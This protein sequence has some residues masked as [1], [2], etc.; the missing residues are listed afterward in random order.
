[1]RLRRHEPL[2]PGDVVALDRPMP[3]GIALPIGQVEHRKGPAA[4]IRLVIGK[5]ELEGRWSDR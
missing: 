1:L 2:A 3:I 5:A 4:T